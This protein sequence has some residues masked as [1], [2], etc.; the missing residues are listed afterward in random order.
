VVLVQEHAVGKTQDGNNDEGG[1][2]AHQSDAK[3]LC[4]PVR[5]ERERRRD[6]LVEHR[7]ACDCAKEGSQ[8]VPGEMGPS[9]CHALEVNGTTTEKVAKARDASGQDEGINEHWQ[10]AIFKHHSV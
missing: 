5:Q 2:T 10:V 9:P 1:G 8:P 7:R 4:S 3:K 6:G